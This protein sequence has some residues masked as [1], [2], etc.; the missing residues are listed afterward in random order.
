MI[1]MMSL[2]DYLVS[3]MYH[4]GRSMKNRVKVAT[5]G[6]TVTVLI[7]RRCSDSLVGAL[8]CCLPSCERHDE[9]RV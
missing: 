1:L 4:I 9:L 6:D 5:V 7:R 3:F 8:A 2:C